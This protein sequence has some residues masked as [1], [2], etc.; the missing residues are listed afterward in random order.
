MADQEVP[1][2]RRMPR[3]SPALVV[4]VIALVVAAGGGAMA[5]LPDSDGTIHGCVGARGALRVIEPP[6]TCEAGEAPLDFNQTGPPGE[7]GPAGPAGPEL[8]AE[9]TSF[10]E[11][12][13]GPPSR[14][15]VKKPGPPKLSR[16]QKLGLA[17]EKGL[18]AFSVYADQLQVVEEFDPAKPGTTV[19]SLPLPAGNWVISAKAGVNLAPIKCYLQAG[20]DYDRLYTV[21]RGMIVGMVVHRFAAI[22]KAVLR[23][24]GVKTTEFLGKLIGGSMVADVKLTAVEVNKITNKKV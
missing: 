9:Q 4:A 1:M 24:S 12:T 20:Q 23:C 19:A 21:E 22:G 16:K 17:P 14:A 3:P 6:T 10:A 7:R 11:A 2:L 8:T 5:A 18:E 13:K 15:E